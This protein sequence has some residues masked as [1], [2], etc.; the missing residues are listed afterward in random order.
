MNTN[1]RRSKRFADFF[2]ICE[3]FTVVSRN[4]VL[5]RLVDFDTL[6]AMT[7][8]PVVQHG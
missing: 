2:M 5:S 7:M 3:L 8:Y 4:G 6:L 1:L